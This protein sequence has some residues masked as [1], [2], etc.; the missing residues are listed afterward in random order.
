MTFLA[1]PRLGD[2]FRCEF[3]QPVGLFVDF[4]I[5]VPALAHHEWHGQVKETVMRSPELAPGNW[6]AC[7]VKLQSLATLV[8]FR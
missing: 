8:P 6:M 5:L 7:A 1:A 2:E 3:F 4:A